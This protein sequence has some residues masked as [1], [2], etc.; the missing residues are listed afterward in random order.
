MG[1]VRLKAPLPLGKLERFPQW[2]DD[3]PPYVEITTLKFMTCSYLS[4]MVLPN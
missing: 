4:G 2:A 3:F 1:A